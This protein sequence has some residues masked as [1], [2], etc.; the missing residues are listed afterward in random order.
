[1][2]EL[3]SLK[4]FKDDVKDVKENMECGISIKTLMTSK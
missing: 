3:A 1:M 2:A 4:R